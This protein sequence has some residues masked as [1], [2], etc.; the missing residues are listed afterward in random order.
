MKQSH[1]RKL[2]R[3]QQSVFYDTGL[4]AKD[5]M[6]LGR[7]GFN[8]SGLY[9]HM[10]N[11]DVR[12]R[13]IPVSGQSDKRS[14]KIYA[15]PANPAVEEMIAAALTRDYY[16]KSLPSAVAN[17]LEE[18]V[19]TII[20]ANEV[21]YEIVY[22]V[23]P[24]SSELVGFDLTRLSPLSLV[25]QHGK[26]FQYVPKS[27]AEKLNVPQYI[28]LDQNNLLIIRP[29]S[30]QKYRL[31]KMMDALTELSNRSYPEFIVQKGGNSIPYESN[32]QIRTF[33]TALGRI[34]KEVG[35]DARQYSDE[36]IT[37][38]YLIERRLRFEEFAIHLREEIIE[39]LNQALVKAGQKIRF[40]A[41]I[42]LE[43][44]PTFDEIKATRSHLEKGDRPF[45]ELMT[46]YS[47]Y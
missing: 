38:Y 32:I 20:A 26:L 6:V 21:V 5:D 4:F 34:T 15:S 16:T 37:E 22:L 3:L 9:P 42:Q 19:G 8:F 39:A 35:W 23:E 46:P 31:P 24:Q 33:D 2:K 40:T 29:H 25:H 28:D 27:I 18:S 1:K 45:G 36:N 7:Q 11:E 12:Y 44:L 30:L 47:Y 13:V 43:G 14:I 41:Q 17:F 10:F